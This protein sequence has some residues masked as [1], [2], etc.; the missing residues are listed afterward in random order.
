MYVGCLIDISCK[1]CNLIRNSKQIC[2]MNL[3]LDFFFKLNNPTFI[4]AIDVG[5][6]IVMQCINCIVFLNSKKI[7]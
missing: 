7:C 2:K 6:I 3:F 5:S 1:N 4:F